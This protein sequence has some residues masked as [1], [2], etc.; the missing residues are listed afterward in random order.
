MADEVDQAQ[1]VE[2]RDR[3]LALQ[4]RQPELPF[5]GECHSC[6]EPV[7]APRLYCDSYCREDHERELAARRRGGRSD[8]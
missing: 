4:V 5:T 8:V 2:E 3:K 6:R 7:S 1:F